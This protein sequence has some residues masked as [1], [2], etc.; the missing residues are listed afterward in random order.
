MRSWSHRPQKFANSSSANLIPASGDQDHTISPHAW[1]AL[2]SR[3]QKR[4]SHPAPNVR[5]DRDTPIL[6]GRETR[7]LRPVICPMAQVN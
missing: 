7:E 4:P 1:A 2:V 5:D 3:C 6:T